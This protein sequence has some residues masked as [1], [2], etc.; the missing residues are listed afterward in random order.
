MICMMH[1]F[2]GCDLLLGGSLLSIHF[3]DGVSSLPV[4]S[5]LLAGCASLDVLWSHEFGIIGASLFDSNVGYL[6]IYIDRSLSDLG[7]VDMKAGAAVF[8]ENIGMGLGVGVSGLMFSILMELKTIALAL[9]CI[10]FSHS[11]DLFSNSQTALDACKLKIKLVC[12]DFRNQCWIEHHHIVNIICHK[13]LRVNWCKIKKHSRV[14]DNEWADKLAR[15]AALFGWHLSYSVNK[16]YLRGGGETIFGNSRHFKISCGTGVVAGSLHTNI[17]WFRSSLTASFRTYFIKTLHHRLPVTMYKWLYDK[18][19]PSVMCLFCGDV[20]V[21]DHVFS[22]P[23]DADGHAQL[24]DAYVAVWNVHSGLAHSSSG[25][26][27]LLSTCVFNVSVSTALYKGFVFKNW[28]RKSVSVFKDSRIASQNIVV[29]VREF[30]LAFW[31]DIW[32]VH[33]KHHAFMEKNGPILCNKSAPVPISGLSLRLSSGI[34]WLLGVAKAI[35]V[36]FRFRIESKIS[37]YIG[38]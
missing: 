14:S 5:T 37:V 9:K 10:P 15:T 32:L 8:F 11:I 23:F 16:R 35:G 12:L 18:H 24:L 38:A 28:F 33:A 21:S 25:V 26:S 36:G 13:N 27:Q 2:S 31:E 34:T 22:Y 6:S 4:C 7:T 17:D 1:I 3:L 29:F 30:S 20:E 19:Y